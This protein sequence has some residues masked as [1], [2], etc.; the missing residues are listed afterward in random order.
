MKAELSPTATMV[1]R[2]PSIASDEPQSKILNDDKPSNDAAPSTAL[3]APR[4]EGA[5][6]FVTWDGP[7]D[8][9]NPKNW[10]YAYKWWVT[11]IVCILSLDV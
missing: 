6:E 3:E 7:D 5:R 11:I 1:E 4:G 8:P 2:P 10:S 9:E